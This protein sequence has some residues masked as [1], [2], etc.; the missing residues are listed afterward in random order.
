MKAIRV[1]A[2]GGPEV[3][4]LADVERPEPKAGD[5]LL[6]I[7]AAGVNYMDVGQR[8]GR[9][10]QT[11]PYIPGGEGSGTV[12]AVG[13]GVEGVKPG[14]RVA[15][16]MA[17]ESYAEFAVVPAA[18]L[19]SVPADLDLV[20][21]AALPLQGLTAHYLLHDYAKVGP[22]TTVLVHAVAGGVGL[23]LTQYATHLGA[24]VIG[25]TSSPEKAAKA[26]AAGARD[27]I[28]YTQT[29]FVDEVKRITGGK[30]VDLILDSVGKTTFPGDL[31]AVRTRGHIV[32]F[33]GASGQADPIVPN[34]LGARALTLSGGSLG[35]FIATR[36]ELLGRAKDLFA[37][38]REGWLKLSIEHVLPLAQ[39]SEAHRL[40]ESRTTSGKLLLT[41]G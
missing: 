11:V 10:G 28:L 37:G 39:A 33:G 15:Y 1:A 7:A 22:G 26:K 35:N 4:T 36:E 16:A 24:H 2:F 13:S 12:E 3:L 8:R 32:V 5:V 25:T 17:P 6:R 40:I 34:S 14:D 27:V 21:A 23:L 31:E 20:Q 18:R 30:G 29:N 41:P 38:L 9:P 19:L